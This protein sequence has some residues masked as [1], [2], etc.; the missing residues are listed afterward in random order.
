M[1]KASD[2][3]AELMDSFEKVCKSK[4]L[5]ITHQRTEIFRMLIQNPNHP[6]TEDI[7]NQVRKHLSTISLDTVYRTIGTFEEYGLIRKVHHID[8][9]TRFDHNL[10]IHHHLVCT[11]CGKIED[12]YWPYFDRM[13]PPKSISRWGEIDLKH[14][15]I[16]GI[17]SSCSKKDI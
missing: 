10:S 16:D 1:K 12:F 8:N 3:V 5:R 14:V 4:G 17:C 9:A 2:H 15:V 7:F 6:T 13:K 11:Q